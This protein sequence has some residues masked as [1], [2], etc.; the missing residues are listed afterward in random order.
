MN[1]RMGQA[2]ADVGLS[3]DYGRGPLPRAEPDQV[4]QQVEK[5]G[6]GRFVGRQAGAVQTNLV[7]KQVGVNDEVKPSLQ[8][9]TWQVDLI[10]MH[11]LGGARG[12][13]MLAVDTGTRKVYGRTMATK[14]GD[15]IVDA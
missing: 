10:D 4:V 9:S 15:D 7:D 1:R 14:T 2:L 8:G 6:D 12:F 13:A 5:G 11:T 3:E